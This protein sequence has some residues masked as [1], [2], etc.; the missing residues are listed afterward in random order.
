M[1]TYQLYSQYLK[2]AHVSTAHLRV[3]KHNLHI[4]KWNTTEQ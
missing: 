2:T 1:N 3:H 4:G